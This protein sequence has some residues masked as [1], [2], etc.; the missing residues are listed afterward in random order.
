MAYFTKLGHV[1]G[2]I[3]M[4]LKKT[5]TSACTVSIILSNQTPSTG[6][7]WRYISRLAL[8]YHHPNEHVHMHMH[9][10]LMSRS[11]G[12]KIYHL[13]DLML[14]QVESSCMCVHMIPLLQ[15]SHQAIARMRSPFQSNCK[16]LHGTNVS[17][18]WGCCKAPSCVHAMVMCLRMANMCCDVQVDFN[19]ESSRVQ[20]AK[21]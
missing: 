8:S 5:C 15:S 21:E 19:T 14:L 6:I 10:W 3:S 7:A 9:S 20:T 13:S 4:P 2:N 12:L 1:A 18:E 16:V 17:P 11:R